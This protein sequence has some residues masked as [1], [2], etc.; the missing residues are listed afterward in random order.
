MRAR[1]AVQNGG[2]LD[3]R[4]QLLSDSFVALVLARTSKLL[5]KSQL[6]KNNLNLVKCTFCDLVFFLLDLIGCNLVIQ[7][8]FLLFI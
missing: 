2:L 7:N 1:R 4:Q 5:L 6:L 8:M 3:S